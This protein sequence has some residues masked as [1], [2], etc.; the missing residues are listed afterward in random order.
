MQKTK[1]LFGVHCHQPVGAYDHVYQFACDRAYLP[2]L[3]TLESCPRIK[4][5]AH[6]SG[7]LYDWFRRN[8]PELMELIRKLVKRGQLELLTSGYYEPILSSI[9]EE[10]RLGQIGMA[11]DFIREQFLRPPRGLWLTG[12]FWEP[13]LPRL[14]AQAGV[15]YVL[16]DR[17][18]FLRA[19][20]PAER[21]GGYYVT[22]E[23]GETVKIFPV[24]RGLEQGSGTIAFVGEG[25]R[26]QENGELER[27][28]SLVD[29]DVEFTTFSNYLDENPARG[30]VY[31][32]AGEGDFRSILVKH[33]E[34]D[35]L[36][37]KMLR[38]SGLL[39]MLGEGKGL[40]GGGRREE[41]LKKARLEL[42]RGQCGYVYGEEGVHLDHLRQAAYSHLIR[43]E[44]E[45]ERLSRGG[46][47]FV[48]LTISDFDKDGEDEVILSN[49]LLNLYFSPTRGGALFE[50]DYKPKTLNLMDT[51]LSLVDHFFGSD[52]S[53]VGDFASNRYQFLPRRQGAEVSLRL[54]R[55]GRVEGAPVK[56][57]KSISLFGKHSIFTVEYEV[58]NLGGEP[59]EFWFGVELNLGKL[60]DEGS[61]FEVLFEFDKP[62]LPQ[63]FPSWK[64]RLEPKQAWRV[65]ITLRIEE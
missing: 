37:K 35:S 32:P 61:G 56:V 21:L 10:D 7:T 15:E 58:M 3:E 43:S 47:S 63:R 36:H 27:L 39:S 42:Y 41:E 62:A 23:M 1:L 8:R 59:D 48:E 34:T 17:E 53:E 46:K 6:F 18:R 9:P 50:L 45:I 26:L 20:V 25:E 40:F 14:L 28:V 22:D 2:L 60:V 52:E 4:F 54:S 13:S 57:E 5:A 64:F 51:K 16:V 24:N 38:V 31:L 29:Q 33:P 19:G 44:R 65:K 11:S 55:E 30:K 12:G 49:D